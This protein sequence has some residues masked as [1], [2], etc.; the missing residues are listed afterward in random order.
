[1]R[2]SLSPIQL[3]LGILALAVTFANSAHATPPNLTDFLA[4]ETLIEAAI[5]PD[6]D[7]V[8]TLEY[9]EGRTRIA[10]SQFT[11]GQG[12]APTAFSLV[13]LRGV[14]VDWANDDRLVVGIVVWSNTTGLGGIPFVRV[15]AVNPDGSNPVQLFGQANQFSLNTDLSGLI[16]ELPKE[17][18]VVLMKASDAAGALN[19]Y[20]VNVLTGQ[21]LLAEQGTKDTTTWIPNADGQLRVRID[22]LEKQ[23]LRRIFTRNEATG[24]W[25]LVAEH[26]T[27]RALD[28]EI[29]GL[30]EDPTVF[31]VR[32]THRHDK[33]GLHYYDIK[34]NKILRK[35]Y[36]R[37]D[38][39]SIGAA[40]S[41]HSR[42]P[43]AAFYLS[44]KPVFDFLDK[45]TKN[46]VNKALSGLDPTT[47]LHN[48]DYDRSG[49]RWIIETQGPLDPGSYH[50]VDLRTGTRTEIGTRR[51]G[52]AGSSLAS[53][54]AYI[55][56]ARDG[57]DIPA[58]LTTP[59]RSTPN[60]LPLIVMPHGGPEARDV[61]QFDAIAQFLASRG[62][63]VF[64]P[65]FRGSDGYGRRYA[66]LGYGE[67]GGQMQTDLI[68]GLQDLIDR[69]IADPNRVCIVGASYGGYAALIGSIQTPE[70]FKCA[71]SI[72][73]VTDLPDA[74]EEVRRQFGANSGTYAYVRRAIGRWP[75]DKDKL[76]ALS[77]ARNPDK[78]KLPVLLIHG[79]YDDVVSI[80]QAI[81]MRDG[82]VRLGKP[83]SYVQLNQSDHHQTHPQDLKQMLV[84]LDLFLIRHL[85]AQVS[86]SEMSMPTLTLSQRGFTERYGT[87][88]WDKLE[89][90]DPSGDGQKPDPLPV[91]LT[92][93]TARP[94]RVQN[95]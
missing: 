1:M 4:P 56:S 65:N 31:V 7:R 34:T 37:N 70:L 79:V 57:L 20:R 2:R 19:A 76:I 55:Y 47:S 8:A 30:T 75:E 29:V 50:K 88:A 38:Y 94:A 43:I 9:S 44:E 85:T 67:W 92:D 90:D 78:V 93:F 26:S 41:H 11:A 71:V 66:A 22:M 14:F 74:I 68:D 46:A 49:Q 16:H 63:A 51:P 17:P 36:Q 12:P 89:N 60:N 42:T 87:D 91:N 64:Q 6:G 5:S 39:D 23:G 86:S 32:A 40:T 25:Q 82:L 95:R 33:T 48:F 58:Y 52:L 24:D 15:V 45:K 18:N 10:V 69:G 61:M 3:V 77:P 84:A 83:V 28:G 80:N 59:A 62:F 35:F 13:D 53:M 73:G 72:A 81:K 54:K 21:A 27:Y